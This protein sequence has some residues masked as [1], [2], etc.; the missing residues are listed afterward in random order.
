MIKNSVI[1]LVCYKWF[2]IVHKSTESVNNFK[3]FTK[4]Y[5]FLSYLLEMYPNR[6][7][8]VYKMQIMC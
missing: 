6:K 5:S 7:Y 8:L 1:E 3:F 2:T 4:Q